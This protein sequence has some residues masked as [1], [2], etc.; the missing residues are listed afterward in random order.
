MKTSTLKFFAIISIVFYS[1]GSK[2]IDQQVKD[3]VNEKDKKE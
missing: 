2:T 1:C 3:L